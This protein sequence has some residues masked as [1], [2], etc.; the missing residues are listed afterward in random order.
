MVRGR[1][2]HPGSAEGRPGKPART[3]SPHW[4]GNRRYLVPRERERRGLTF[5]EQLRGGKLP[6]A[7]GRRR[8][9]CAPASQRAPGPHIGAPKTM[10]APR[11]VM[12]TNVGDERSR[13][14][15]CAS[16]KHERT[17]CAGIPQRCARG[18]GEE[19]ILDLPIPWKFRMSPIPVAR[20]RVPFSKSLP[21]H[22]RVRGVCM[23]SPWSGFGTIQCPEKSEDSSFESAILP[24]IRLSFSDRAQRNVIWV[25]SKVYIPHVRPEKPKSGTGPPRAR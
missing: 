18:L 23:R 14:V 22:V 21:S 7:H 3:G 10:G 1:G 12:R 17:A 5:T 19:R 15:T 4:L 2:Q 6:G 16:E 9:C 8:F 25:R 13:K 20:A 24:G 11:P